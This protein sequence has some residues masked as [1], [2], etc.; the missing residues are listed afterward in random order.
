ASS[1]FAETLYTVQWTNASGEV[2]TLKGWL[3]HGFFTSVLS[4]LNASLAFAIFNVLVLFAFA[5]VLYSRKIFI[6]V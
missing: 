4:D 1:L 5:W 3:Y 2:T 6:K